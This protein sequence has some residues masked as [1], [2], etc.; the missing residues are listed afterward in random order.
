MMN[1]HRRHP[2]SEQRDEIFTNA[3]VRE[4]WMQEIMSCDRKSMVYLTQGMSQGRPKPLIF[5]SFLRSSTG[6]SHATQDLHARL[7][8]QGAH[9][10]CHCH[11][12]PRHTMSCQCHVGVMSCHVIP[13]HVKPCRTPVLPCHT[14]PLLRK[15]LRVSCCFRGL[16]GLSFTFSAYACMCPHDPL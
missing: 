11:V 10:R 9:C 12:M 3:R 2:E 6:S 14:T 7:H 5:R 16:P 4:A 13:C 8:T 1:A 15:L